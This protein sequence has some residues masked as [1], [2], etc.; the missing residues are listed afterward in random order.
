MSVGRMKDYIQRTE[1][2]EQF[3]KD[4]IAKFGKHL[5]T[6]ANIIVHERDEYLATTLCEVARVGFL[7]PQSRPKEGEKGRVV[8]GKSKSK[9]KIE[10]ELS[11][12]IYWCSVSCFMCSGALDSSYLLLPYSITS[13]A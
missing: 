11:F 10:S 9:S 7:H 8:A 6:F 13:L 4:E 2:D 1:K 3:I 5:P 12:S